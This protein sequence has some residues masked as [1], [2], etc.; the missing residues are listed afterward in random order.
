MGKLQVALLPLELHLLYGGTYD[1][2]KSKAYSIDLTVTHL[3]FLN[4]CRSTAQRNNVLEDMVLVVTVH[5]V[6]W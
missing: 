6:L 4:N 2:F 1:T 3:T 5:Y